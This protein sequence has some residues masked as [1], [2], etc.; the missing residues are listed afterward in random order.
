MSSQAS[1]TPGINHTVLSSTKHTAVPT[2]QVCQAGANSSWSHVHIWPLLE[3]QRSNVVITCHSQDGTPS[4]DEECHV[5]GTPQL[6]LAAWVEVIVVVDEAPVHLTSLCA[7]AVL[8]LAHLDNVCLAGPTQCW[9]QAP[10]G[11][12]AYMKQKTASDT[13]IAVC[14]PGH[15]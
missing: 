3:A 11:L 9:V 13:T 6:L 4:P 14:I 15:V 2:H 8:R 1:A 5:H 12:P 7:V 10:V